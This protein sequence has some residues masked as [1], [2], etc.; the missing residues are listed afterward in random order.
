MMAQIE[1][2]YIGISYMCISVVAEQTAEG[3]QVASDSHIFL[4]AED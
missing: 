3:Q 4:N 1:K 2:Q